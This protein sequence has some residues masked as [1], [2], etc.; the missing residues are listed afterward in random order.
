MKDKLTTG[1]TLILIF[2][3][4]LFSPFAGSA[5]SQPFSPVKEDSLKL[6]G[7]LQKYQEHYRAQ[8]DQL[9]SQYKKD[10]VDVYQQRWNNIRHTF[11]SKEIYTDAS[12]QDYLNRLVA[13]IRKG[14]PNLPADFT[15]YFSRSA[16]PNASYIGEGI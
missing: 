13:V 14:N 6:F 12:A 1:F 16:I 5:Q 9:P 15:C 7:L 3:F 8:L 2:L 10:L 11:E 4:L